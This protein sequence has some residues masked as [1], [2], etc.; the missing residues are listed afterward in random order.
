MGNVLR[1]DSCVEYVTGLE[2]CRKLFTVH[3]VPH[4]DAA[5]ENCEDFLAVVDMPLVGLICPMES[6]SD[7]VHIGNVQSS[8][9]S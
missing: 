7:T 3:S 6:G 8:P 2:C 9:S 1:S 5:I 4:F